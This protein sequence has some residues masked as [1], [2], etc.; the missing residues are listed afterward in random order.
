M[1]SPDRTG[2]LLILWC[3]YSDE[4]R[5]VRDMSRVLLIRWT[6]VI[7]LGFTSTHSPILEVD[8]PY[9]ENRTTLQTANRYLDIVALFPWPRHFSGCG[10]HH[11]ANF[12]HLII[13]ESFQVAKVWTMFILYGAKIL[14]KVPH[15][16]QQRHRFTYFV[17]LWNRIFNWVR[18]VHL[19]VNIP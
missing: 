17:H 15:K 7:Q 5:D 2:I 13:H 3:S 6:R 12:I 16:S 9:V 4:C 8:T 10:Y 11:H 1:S 19:L 18:F 14:M